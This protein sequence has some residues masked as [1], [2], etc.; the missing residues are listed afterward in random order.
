MATF[1]R[2]KD[3]DP[4]ADWQKGHSM[5]KVLKADKKPF[6]QRHPV[7]LCN[8]HEPKR[9][10]SEKQVF[11][12]VENK[13][14]KVTEIADWHAHSMKTVEQT[15]KPGYTYDDSHPHKAAI[16]QPK[17]KDLDVQH[18]N[19]VHPRQERIQRHRGWVADD[20]GDYEHHAFSSVNKV[21]DNDKKVRPNRGWVSDDIGDMEG[22]G[23]SSV[24]KVVEN[25]PKRKVAPR[26]GW[27]S[28]DNGD[29]EGHGYSSVAKVVENEPKRQY[30]TRHA[31]DP[32]DTS[33]PRKRPF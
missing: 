20:N 28:D 9:S 33:H 2:D 15:K 12:T 17:K 32:V 16:E 18:W 6:E 26:R 3:W 14:K 30:A 23:Y 31:L 5:D 11:K 10:Y 13:P 21:V 4:A 24:A 29:M 1:G 7:S 25:E 19:K 22:H 27:V 8:T